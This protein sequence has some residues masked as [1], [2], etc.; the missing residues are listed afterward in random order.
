M[1][2]DYPELY[3]RVYPKVIDTVDKHLSSNTAI[4]SIT[5][6]DIEKMIDEV[7]IKM[8]KEYPE[9]HE[10]PLERR[11]RGSRVK[12]AQRHFF[13]RGRL[14]RDLITIILISELL[15]RHHSGNF[16]NDPY[17]YPW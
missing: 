1:S 14:T 3:Y 6:E 12:S 9:I 16:W 5:D 2:Y 10:D 13:G 17:T 11:G 15:R 4:E 7:Y 8:V